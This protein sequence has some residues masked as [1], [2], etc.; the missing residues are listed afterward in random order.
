LNKEE[1][2]SKIERR[3][4]KHS[5]IATWDKREQNVKSDSINFDLVVKGDTSKISIG[6]LARF[7]ASALLPKQKVA[8]LVTVVEREQP[9]SV[10]SLVEIANA[11]KKYVIAEKLRWVWLVVAAFEDFLA[12]TLRFA[13][14]YYEENMAIIL[15]NLKKEKVA[16]FT[17]SGL[18]RS[19][20]GL[21]KP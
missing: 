4:S 14:E 7:L 20:S 2:L 5:L 19:G 12:N 17:R 3:L 10:E 21:L 8:V 16:A 9:M 15:V 6:L 18:G 11:G 1:Y 13:E